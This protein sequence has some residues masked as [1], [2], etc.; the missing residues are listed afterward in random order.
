[1]L[2]EPHTE[3][4]RGLTATGTTLGFERQQIKDAEC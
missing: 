4:G 3:M 1:M 2:Q